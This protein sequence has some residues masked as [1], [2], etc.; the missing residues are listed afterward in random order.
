MMMVMPSNHGSIDT[1][2]YTKPVGNGII[3]PRRKKLYI[4]H[5]SEILFPIVKAMH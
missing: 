3:D 4:A 5:M 1:C 2:L